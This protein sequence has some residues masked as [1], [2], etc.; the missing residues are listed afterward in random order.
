MYSAI[1]GQTAV[2]KQMEVIAN[3]LANATTA[4]F[5]AE[6]ILFE[7]VLTD[8]QLLY[9]SP[10]SEI[11]DPNSLPLDEYVQIKG[12]FTD[13]SLGPVENTGNPLD[14]AIRNEG[15]FILN[16]PEGVRY[17]RSGQFSLDNQNR[18]VSS[19]G[20]PVQGASGEITLGAGKIEISA[21]GSISLNGEFV[22]Q[23]RLAKLDSPFLIRESAQKYDLPPEGIATDLEKIEVQARAI[24]GSN[25]NTVKELT[26]M[27]FASRMFEALQKAQQASSSMTEDRNQVLGTS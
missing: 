10:N 6:R 25:V 26:D 11:S 5:K 17:T 22:D 7:K 4:G 21:D 27:I 23:L 19:E 18:L 24:E 3:N 13:L 2:F 16:T 8:E 12:S 20:H 14:V 1:S 15:F 9:Y